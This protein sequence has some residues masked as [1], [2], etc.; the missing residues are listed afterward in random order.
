MAYA[1][2]KTR[3]TS[4]LHPNFRTLRGM[5]AYAP[6]TTRDTNGLRPSFRG[7]GDIGPTSIT[8]GPGGQWS[9]SSGSNA[10]S[11]SIGDQLSNW[12]GSSTVFAG[13][14]NSLVAIAGAIGLY[15]LVRRKR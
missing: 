13:V 6:L 5:G 2:L 7:M 12:L 15:A 11:T 10:T 1:S 8:F 14:P 4:G 3:N 9:V